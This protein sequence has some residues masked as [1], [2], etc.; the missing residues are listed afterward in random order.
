MTHL[1]VKQKLDKTPQSERKNW[2]NKSTFESKKWKKRK[3]D[4]KSAKIVVVGA[5]TSGVHFASLLKSKG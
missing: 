4:N 2:L 1:Y 5:G 3:W